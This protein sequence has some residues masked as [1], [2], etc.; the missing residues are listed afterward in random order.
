MN[1]DQECNQQQLQF[2]YDNFNQSK[3][4]IETNEQNSG[5]ACCRGYESCRYAGSITFTATTSDIL[6]CS[7]YQSCRGV[8]ITAP[9]SVF[10]EGIGACESTKIN[11]TDN[12][13]C[14]GFFACY[15]S[16]ITNSS[17]VYC[18]GGSACDRSVIKNPTHVH[19]LGQQSGYGTK[20]H[21]EDINDKCE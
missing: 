12:L 1:N 4:I 19:L 21:C 6:V 13:Y 18:S 3:Q 11:K 14:L 5:P 8:A 16:Y 20:I 15:L 10:C 2:V 7:G 9:H 17:V